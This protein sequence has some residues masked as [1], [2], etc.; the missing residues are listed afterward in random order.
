MTLL[1]MFSLVCTGLLHKAHAAENNSPPRVAVVSKNTSASSRT[2]NVRALLETSLSEESD[3]QVVEREK[4]SRIFK[5]QSRTKLFSSQTGPDQTAFWNS[6]SGVDLFVMLEA[7]SEDDSD[8]EQAKSLRVRLVDAHKGIKHAD[9]S[10]PLAEEEAKIQN[11]VSLLSRKVR[12]HAVSQ[13][14]TGKDRPLIALLPFRCLN[15]TEKWSYIQ[16]VL[17]S[18]V[19]HRLSLQQDVRLLEHTQA[20]ILHDERKLTD[21]LP[22]AIA[23]ATVVVDGEFEV[24][25]QRERIDLRVRIRSK[26]HETPETLRFQFDLEKLADIPAEI[27]PRILK[28]LNPDSDKPEGKRYDGETEARLLLQEA[29]LQANP[30]LANRL[31]E[32]ALAIAPD[33][34]DCLYDFLD[35]AYHEENGERVD[36]DKSLAGHARDA[37]FKLMSRQPDPEDLTV[38]RANILYACAENVDPYQPPH[39]E[40]DIGM[41]YLGMNRY[42]VAAVETC[43]QGPRVISL[44]GYRE[45][46]TRFVR[47]VLRT[48]EKWSQDPHEIVRLMKW[49]S[50]NCDRNYCDAVVTAWEYF[51]SDDRSP[52]EGDRYRTAKEKM[53]TFFRELA[54]SENSAK[55]ALGHYAVLAAV[56]RN[57]D[58]TDTEKREAFE[59]Y[60]QMYIENR[61][62]KNKKLC[63][64]DWLDPFFR[65]ADEVYGTDKEDQNTKADYIS[66]VAEGVLEEYDWFK[67]AY[68]KVRL[69]ADAVVF[70]HDAG[71]QEE[72]LSLAKDVSETI[73]KRSANDLASNMRT[74]KRRWRDITEK[75]FSKLIEKGMEGMLLPGEDSDFSGKEVF[76]KGGSNI[77]STD[78]GLAIIREREIIHLDNATF[79]PLGK[80]TLPSGYRI[81]RSGHAVT[82]G[83]TVCV[84]LKKGIAVFAT[85]RDPFV[86]NMTEQELEDGNIIGFDILNGKVYIILSRE[87]GL[88]GETLIAWN[89][90]TKESS[91]ILS[92]H[93]DMG[94]P[95]SLPPLRGIRDVVAD[96]FRNCLRILPNTRENDAVMLEYRPDCETFGKVKERRYSNCLRRGRMLYMAEGG[97][98]Y[99]FIDIKTGIEMSRVRIR[100]HER[101]LPEYFKARSSSSPFHNP[102]KTFQAGRGVLTI[103]SAIL[104]SGTDEEGYKSSAVLFYTPPVSADT[105][106]KL[107]KEA[108]G[109]LSPKDLGRHIVMLNQLLFGNL[110]QAPEKIRSLR[111]TER[112]LLVLTESRLLLSPG[113]SRFYEA[114]PNFSQKEIRHACCLYRAVVKGLAD[115]PWLKKVLRRHFGKAAVDWYEANA[116]ELKKQKNKLK[117]AFWDV[118][119]SENAMFQE[120]RLLLRLGESLRVKSARMN[121]SRSDTDEAYKQKLNSSRKR[122]YKTLYKHYTG[123]PW[124]TLAGVRYARLLRSTVY[125]QHEKAQEVFKA[126]MQQ[127]DNEYVKDAR[128]G[129]LRG[130]SFKG[131]ITSIQ[132]KLEQYDIDL[133]N[134]TDIEVSSLESNFAS[135]VRAVKTRLPHPACADDAQFEA[136]RYLLNICTTLKK[137]YDADVL[138]DWRSRNALFEMF[139]YLLHPANP[140]GKEL[141][142]DALAA[143]PSKGFLLVLLLRY[144]ETKHLEAFLD[145]LSDPDE[146]HDTDSAER[147]WQLKH[148]FLTVYEFLD[149][150]E[151]IPYRERIADA[152]LTGLKDSSLLPVQF[153]YLNVLESFTEYSEV[154]EALRHYAKADD[155][156]IR[157][158]AAR[159][160]SSFDPLMALRQLKKLLKDAPYDSG[161]DDA[162]VVEEYQRVHRVL[163]NTLVAL[164]DPDRNSREKAELSAVAKDCV[165]LFTKRLP[166]DHYVA[167]DWHQPFVRD[168]LWPAGINVLKDRFIEQM[169]TSPSF[170]LLKQA[171]NKKSE[172][173]L[174]SYRYW[175]MDPKHA[176]IE[177]FLRLADKKLDT[178]SADLFRRIYGREPQGTEFR[179]PDPDEYSFKYR[180]GAVVR[181]AENCNTPPFREAMRQLVNRW[182][183]KQILKEG[184][185]EEDD[186]QELVNIAKAVRKDKKLQS[187]F[188]VNSDSSPTKLVMAAEM[189]YQNGDIN[190]ARKKW[191]WYLNGLTPDESCWHHHRSLSSPFAQFRLAA[192]GLKDVLNKNTDEHNTTENE[193]AITSLLSRVW[194]HP[195]YRHEFALL[196]QAAGYPDKAWESIASPEMLSVEHNK[197]NADMRLRAALIAVQAEKYS[198]AERLLSKLAVTADSHEERQYTLFL[199]KLVTSPSRSHLRHILN[200]FFNRQRRPAERSRALTEE[201]ANYDDP[202]LRAMAYYTAASALLENPET[203]REQAE[204]LWKKG[205]AQEGYYARLCRRE[206]NAL[207][208]GDSKA[209][210]APSR[211]TPRPLSRN[212][213]PTEHRVLITHKPG[214]S[215]YTSAGILWRDPLGIPYSAYH[216]LMRFRG[217]KG[218]HI[219]ITGWL[220]MVTPGRWT[221]DTVHQPENID[222]IP[223]TPPRKLFNPGNEQFSDYEIHSFFIEPMWE[224]G[225][226]KP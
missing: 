123:S 210:L 72:A 1:S 170:D 79:E 202:R 131:D 10:L 11:L 162:L 129:F 31:A 92:I 220:P 96:R 34:S 159:S 109:E 22:E 51:C 14:E 66:R 93:K 120:G 12:N 161:D 73:K 225:S 151:F 21:D 133:Q 126:I 39:V 140:R 218:Y 100:A 175:S 117:P 62:W 142:E 2:A 15:A 174:W 35:F 201:A 8:K 4:I 155:P 121:R 90:Q 144:G 211:Y 41:P 99:T 67:G 27:I 60:A 101:H 135:I 187:D 153:L 74:L 105:S 158:Q 206:R 213:H 19:E 43:K 81:V 52:Y 97:I 86:Y 173:W 38:E 169:Q 185:H 209:M 184:L 80:Q 89:P 143:H 138:D 58:A 132:K 95:A 171:R 59:A 226:M 116:E 26:N 53:L 172:D 197:H 130:M 166:A 137:K 214:R 102:H 7:S 182:G 124:H 176:D 88:G 56:M 219:S 63:R 50:R 83:D 48:T 42:V 16:G 205:A 221:V 148:T 9:L 30:E 128:R 113:M 188:Q 195:E 71:R 32:S 24:K 147:M 108:S 33:N 192:T 145:W 154:R 115:E 136:V 150:P 194:P 152:L 65:V 103:R 222:R 37:F 3:L 224:P 91:T 146:R 198:A 125:N 13:D 178:P 40:A 82:E 157:L 46:E 189:A 111:M 134:L 168:H 110:E 119:R 44:F 199:Q 165:E 114:P 69:L 196:L 78:N 20:G 70:L 208:K 181:L 106:Q 186:Q 85:G 64:D 180:S 193:K 203:S 122:A 217:G 215:R 167:Y 118:S 75:P 55:A 25:A 212:V 216:K 104:E 207:P 190:D 54:G 87:G 29:R 164:Q 18:A 5:E 163:E 76:A 149:M 223:K 47:Q 28:T 191:R 177:A 204:S 156:A 68:T 107:F 200:T 160:V 179:L 183:D 49:V 77:V 127:N 94:T 6:L 61:L 139:R 17:T 36:N 141:L 23:A 57:P 98:D 84:R 45:W 112:G